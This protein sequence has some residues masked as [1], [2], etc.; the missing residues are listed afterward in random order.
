MHGVGGIL[1]TLLAGIFCSTSL[2]IF[3][4]NGFS[5]GIDG[6]GGQLAVQA[7]GVAA[8]FAYTG[9]VTFIILKLVDAVVGLRVDGDSETQ[10]LDLVLHE[11]R[12]VA[13]HLS[14]AGLAQV[15]WHLRAPMPWRDETTE[16]AYVL[17]RL[18]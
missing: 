10:G 5:A 8:T 12:T 3:S 6:I 14:A 18:P 16:R 17:G 13:A 9:V 2:G 11:P 15:T 1:G 4:G 7:T